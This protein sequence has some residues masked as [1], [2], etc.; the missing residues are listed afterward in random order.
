MDF[1][2]KDLDQKTA[3]RREPAHECKK[4]CS[5]DAG[6]GRCRMTC[7]DREFGQASA[8][9]DASERAPAPHSRGL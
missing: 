1:D 6:A 2:M 7:R 4:A 8:I 3:H 5:D 9:A